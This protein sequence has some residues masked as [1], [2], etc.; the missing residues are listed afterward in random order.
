MSDPPLSIIQECPPLQGNPDFY[1]L[2]IRMGV[3]LQWLSSWLSLVLDPDLAQSILDVN[4]T[5][6]FAII[7]ATIHSAQS[8]T[9]QAIEMYVMLQLTIGFLVT[10][11]STFGVR[12][13][14][15]TPTRLLHFLETLGKVFRDIIASIQKPQINNNHEHQGISPFLAYFMKFS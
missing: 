9:M 3:Y 14:F 8:G 1:G 7:I 13:Q 5:F 6:V 11:L 15:L 10:N 12:L 4:S 2:G